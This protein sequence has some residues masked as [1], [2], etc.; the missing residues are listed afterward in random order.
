MFQ[1]VIDYSIPPTN[2]IVLLREAEAVGRVAELKEDID[3][4]VAGKKRM[5]REKERLRKAQGGKDLQ[6]AEKQVKQYLPKHL[7][8]HWVELLRNGHRFDDDAE[9]TFA[10]GIE[11]DKEKEMLRV[12]KVDLDVATAPL[13]QLVKVVGKFSLI[14]KQLA[15]ILKKRREMEQTTRGGGTAGEAPYDFVYLRELGFAEE[16]D[17]LER[18]FQMAT[19]EEPDGEPD[20]DPEAA[21]DEV[22]EERD[23]TADIELQGDHNEP[24]TDA[25]ESTTSSEPEVNKPKNE[26]ASPEA[27]KKDDPSPKAKGKGNGK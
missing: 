1:H 8:P 15:P 14:T 27:L 12:Q 6:P 5:I 21:Q 13:D 7:V 16:A 22:R 20:P 23:I 18:R 11:K 4:W 17:E 10:A 25:V 3:S 24:P 19:A 26:P 9:W 2:A